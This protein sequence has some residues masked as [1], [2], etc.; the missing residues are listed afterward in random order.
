MQ[1]LMDIC[2]QFISQPNKVYRHYYAESLSQYVRNI[3]NI[4]FF[5]QGHKHLK[6]IIVDNQISDSSFNILLTVFMC[7]SLL[8]RVS[9]GIIALFNGDS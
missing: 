8:W 2:A 5:F 7:A 9:S 1:R 3:A 6:C 4:L